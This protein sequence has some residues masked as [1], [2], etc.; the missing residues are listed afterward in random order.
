MKYT[1]VNHYSFSI[2]YVLSTG[3]GDMGEYS[4]KND[5]KNI[6]RALLD[7]KAI[8]GSYPP[9]VYNLIG[10]TKETQKILFLKKVM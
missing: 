2:Y 7:L 8:W 3:W 10:K 1:S 5:N 4:V 6:Y 9:E